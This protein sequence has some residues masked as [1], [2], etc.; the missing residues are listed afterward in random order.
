MMIIK[1]IRVVNFC[2]YED[3]TF[4]F[5]QPMSLF[6][7]PNGCGKTTVLEAVR[8]VSNPQV[9][10]GRRLGAETYLRPLIRD[11]DYIPY[12]DAILEKEKEH[13]LVEASFLDLD[14]KEYIVKLDE[15][16]FIRNDLE[17]RQIGRAS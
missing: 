6:Y 7:G 2:G 10:T 8:I 11:E 9:F 12:A 3:S 13:L 17:D 15:T 4:E 1:K 14:G 16:G 5:T